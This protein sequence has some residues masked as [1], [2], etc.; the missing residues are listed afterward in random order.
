MADIGIGMAILKI[1]RDHG[2]EVKTSQIYQAL[3][4]GDYL[5]LKAH[6]LKETIYGGRPAYQH[7]VRSYLSNM[8]QEGFAD[9]IER[10]VY[11]IT[12]LGIK[13]LEI[14]NL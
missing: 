7:E 8:V 3:E 11:R 2:P 6:Q 13:E 5:E 4:G 14:K 12:G 9:R 10:G 1:I